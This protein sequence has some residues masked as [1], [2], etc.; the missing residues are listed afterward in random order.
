MLKKQNNATY[1]SFLISQQENSSA[2]LPNSIL[3]YFLSKKHES[4][5]TLLP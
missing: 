1:L 2:T 5:L 4:V 3:I